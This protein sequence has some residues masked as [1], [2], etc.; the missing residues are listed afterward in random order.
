MSQQKLLDRSQSQGRLV[1]LSTQSRRD[2]ITQHKMIRN[3]TQLKLKNIQDLIKQQSTTDDQ[4]T[5]AIPS[6]SYRSNF[7]DK[8]AKDAKKRNLN[9]L[10]SLQGEVYKQ[11]VINSVLNHKPAINF[12]IRKT[13]YSPY[14]VQI[15]RRF[16]PQKTNV[17]SV[18]KTQID[19]YNNQKIVPKLIMRFKHQSRNHNETVQSMYQKSAG[20]GRYQQL[21]I[22]NDQNRTI[23][24]ARDALKSPKKT[25]DLQ[26]ND[27]NSSQSQFKPDDYLDLTEY[28]SPYTKRENEKVSN[29]IIQM[30]KQKFKE[31]VKEYDQGEEEATQLYLE[32]QKVFVK[33]NSILRTNDEG[34]SILENGI[35]GFFDL[36]DGDV[37]YFS[38]VNDPDFNPK[39]AVKI[40]QNKLYGKTVLYVSDV[41]K[42]P[43]KS[44]ASLILDVKLQMLKIQK[45][46]GK[47][48]PDPKQKQRSDWVYVAV[49]AHSE[50]KGTITLKLD[51]KKSKFIQQLK[52]ERPIKI[53]STNPTQEKL[54]LFF[55][56]KKM[57]MQEIIEDLRNNHAKRS[58]FL[59][60]LNTLIKERKKREDDEKK[61]KYRKF[62]SNIML[63]SNEKD[64]Q[65]E[66][67]FN[68]QKDKR[69]QAIQRKEL[70]D[71]Q[72]HQLLI[73]K[74]HRH[75][76]KRNVQREVVQILQAKQR[77]KDF[78]KHWIILQITQLAMTQLNNRFDKFKSIF[79]KELRQ[80]FC[81]RRIQR[82]FRRYLR[83]FNGRQNPMITI[84]PIHLKYAKFSFLMLNQV[85]DTRPLERSQKLV[86][87]FCVINLGVLHLLNKMKTFYKT[88]EKLKN[89]FLQ[90]VSRR[91]H[92]YIVLNEYWNQI[93]DLCYFIKKN[94]NSSILKSFNG[95]RFS[96]IT[97]AAKENAIKK[98]LRARE[99]QYYHQARNFQTLVNKFTDVRVKIASKCLFN[100]SVHQ[101]MRRTQQKEIKKI[102]GIVQKNI[103]DLI[104]SSSNKNKNKS[105]VKASL[106][107]QFRRM[108]IINLQDSINNDI[109][110]INF[111]S[112]KNISIDQTTTQKDSSI[113]EEEKSSNSEGEQSN[114]TLSITR[115][116]SRNSV[117]KS[118][119]SSNNLM[120]SLRR[121]KNSN[122]SSLKKLSFLNQDEQA[123]QLDDLIIECKIKGVVAPSPE[124]IPDFQ[125]MLEIMNS[126]LEES[127][128]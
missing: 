108:T 85:L 113:Q 58:D 100:L 59:E 88:S 99:N 17:E 95:H 110:T 2:S 75:E 128:T 105:I 20:T 25:I 51:N 28:L 47:F 53:T 93:S 12:N 32:F 116:Q 61:L 104:S 26:I 87:D 64:Q 31:H 50:T 63:S 84:Q 39:Q 78:L 112:L 125:E 62:I 107:S 21:T 52:L 111:L 86:Q 1:P 22:T 122:A 101:V 8:P 3:V 54:E 42:K 81:A 97:E 49:H 7:L 60:Q 9:Q 126:A 79:I 5:T 56:T 4:N 82:H 109:S 102:K 65:K 38:F 90:T 10:D 94:K 119:K 83:K 71:K 118:R 96:N 14:D 114:N 37:A 45:N 74:H 121:K 120:S 41:S 73:L 117:L 40:A 124:F 48:E 72:Q 127:E 91:K 77:K 36:T 106:I 33:L 92:K 57:S 44:S 80:F 18:N 13:S 66:Q 43:N 55:A 67:Y 23:Q 103:M 76:I 98:F 69:N 34:I 6:I 16:L 123:D 15:Q 70:H 27:Q 29:I 89:R 11:E 35:P 24:D 30:P 19:D 115:N 68:S 46:K